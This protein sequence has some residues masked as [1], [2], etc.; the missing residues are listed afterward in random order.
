MKKHYLVVALVLVLLWGCSNSGSSQNRFVRVEGKEFIAP[1]GK[2]I[3]LRG[4]NLGNWLVPEGYMFKFRHATSPRLINTVI[5]ELVGPAEARNF[6][7]Q[8][9]DNYI[10]RE[11]IQFIK[12]CGMNSIRV[13]FNYRLFTP[14]DHPGVWLGPGFEMLDRVI[15][16]CKEAGIWVIL[17]MHCAPGGQTGDN[18]DDS[19]GWPSLFESEES[20]KR[21]AEVWQK[22][23]AR[24]A[25]EPTVL[26]YDLLNEPIPHWD[27]VQY[28]NDRLEPLYK[29]ITAAIRKVDKNHIIILGGRRWDT[30]FDIFG[31]PF[32]DK[33]AYTFHKY[34]SDVTDSSIQEYLDF[35][36]KYNVPLW[37]SESGENNYEWIG[38]FTDLLEK[39]NIGWCFWPYKKMEAPSCIVTFAKPE[40]WDEI[41]E[42]ADNAGTGF[43]ERRAKR[44]DPQHVQAALQGFLQ[45]C[46]FENCTVNDGYLQALRLQ[47]GK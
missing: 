29:Q 36:D 19:W 32:D 44:P 30:S 14:E 37:M 39:Y 6:W 40:Y 25:D 21:V 2:P 3:L 34:W 42:Y 7:A 43:N 28:L 5:S 41:K 10:R 33:L 35:R 31:P 22:I 47:S 1:D 18:I 24:Y 17:D 13:P 27:E 16:W 11:D 12:Q 15:G 26:G 23:A 45:Y 20:Q 38:S 4:M 46:Q 9:Y 8:Y